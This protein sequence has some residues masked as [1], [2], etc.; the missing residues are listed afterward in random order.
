VIFLEEK[1]W[2]KVDERGKTERKSFK[3]LLCDVCNEICNEIKN[4]EAVRTSESNGDG[5]KFSS[6]SLRYGGDVN[7]G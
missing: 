3:S 4:V 1:R 2:Q 7:N 5:D 6:S